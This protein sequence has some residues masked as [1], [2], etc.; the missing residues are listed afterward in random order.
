[1]ALLRRIRPAYGLFREGVVILPH[2]GNVTSFKTFYFSTVL[3]RQQQQHQQ[4]KPESNNE[5]R[6]NDN[7]DSRLSSGDKR[8][9]IDEATIRK[10][11]RLAL[12]GYEYDRSKRVLEETVAFA[13]RLRTARIDDE[14][15][16]PMYST[17]ENECIHLRDDVARRDVDRR[18]ILKNAA[19]LEEEYFVAPLVTTC[20]EKESKPKNDES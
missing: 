13:E 17:L 1:M 10:I 2:R 5:V 7:D 6:N 19:V 8:P 15:V 20:K 12:V 18:E 4:Q 3:T 11:E 9:V 14:T 16:R